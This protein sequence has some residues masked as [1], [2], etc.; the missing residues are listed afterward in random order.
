[1]S[2]R[3]LPDLHSIYVEVDPIDPEVV[4]VIDVSFK[5]NCKLTH[6][7]VRMSDN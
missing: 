6:E 3:L 4:V 1:M 5:V 7:I 2:N